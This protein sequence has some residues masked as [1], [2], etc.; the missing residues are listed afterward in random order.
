M[1]IL[2]QVSSPARYTNNELNAVH[3][4]WNKAAVKMCL[5]FPDLYDIG[6]GNLGFKILYHI[7]NQRP[8]CLGERAYLPWIDM[9]EKMEE[10]GLSLTALESGQ[11]LSAFDIIGFTLQH[12]T[13]YSNVIKMLDIAGIPRWT[14]DRGDEDPLI[15]AGGPCSFNPEPLADF[16]DCII[17]GDGEEI[18]PIILDTVKL[19]KEK[20]LDKELTL[21]E[22]AKL[23]GTYIPSFYQ[24]KYEESGRFIGLTPLH[25]EIPKQIQ[26]NIVW[27]LDQA[28]YPDKIVV[29]YS[30]IIHDRVSV[31]VMRGCTRGCRFCQAGMIYRPVRERSMDTLKEQIRQLIES[32]GY[33]EVSLSSLSTG[34]YN[35]IQELV[36]D[37]VLEYEKQGVSLSLPSLRVDSFSVKLAEEVQKVRKSGITFAPEAGTQ[38]LRNVINKNVN[39][40]ELYE[41]VEGAFKAGWHQIKLYFMIGLP[42]ETYQDLDGIISLANNV[43]KIGREHSQ[44][45]RRRPSVT[46][47]VA[48]FVPKSHTPFQW[49]AM[50]DMDQLLEKQAYLR[51][52]LSQPGIS[53]QVHDVETSYLEGL[54]ARG[55]RRLGETI[56]RAVD[57]GCQF[58][59]W[60]EL[61][62]FQLWTQAIEDTGIN[63]DLYVTRH[64]ERDEIFP[65]AHLESGVSPNYLWHERERALKQQT[66]PDCRLTSC[67]GCGIC[68]PKGDLDE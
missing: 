11:P 35:C 41:A 28:A 43:L 60:R 27:D 45:G 9:Q 50:N 14:K 46:V 53:F 42:T 25:T 40:T 33:N 68:L 51:E 34:D 18:L 57:L 36:T 19:A 59:S 5:A 67:T 62:D 1:Q 6:M 49:E 15:I 17:L 58:D 54:L 52:H 29:P 64:R 30:S 26:K 44:Q 48:S 8:D 3:K 61:F 4:D 16:I 55:D 21:M 32:T 65:W 20:G 22:L 56:A 10:C 31:E 13:S 23:P 7:I 2:P 12:E 63:W 37:L 38:R 24:P 39:E 47:S 66:T